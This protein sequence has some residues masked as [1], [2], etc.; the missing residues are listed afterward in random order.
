MDQFAGATRGHPHL[1]PQFACSLLHA[2]LRSQKSGIFYGYPVLG[3]F[4]CLEEKYFALLS[5][6]MKVQK[7]CKFLR[8]SLFVYFTWSASVGI[9]LFDP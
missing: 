7:G 6:K 4:F 5:M 8:S 3:F 2:W 9:Q 1:S